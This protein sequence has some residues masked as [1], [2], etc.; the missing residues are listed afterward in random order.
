MTQRY[1]M[2]SIT[3]N[4]EAQQQSI[5][6]TTANK[7]SAHSSNSSASSSN[8]SASS[9]NSSASSSNSS[10][11]SSMNNNS[12]SSNSMSSS[13]S[14]NNKD[15]SAPLRSKVFRAT[16]GVLI[17]KE[18]EDQLMLCIIPVDLVDDSTPTTNINKKRKLHECDDDVADDDRLPTLTEIDCDRFFMRVLN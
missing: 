14:G 12:S 2:S 4:Q 11:S 7:E 13:N 9:S 5:R 18:E 15:P 3:Q 16:G 6:F 8:S 10:S 1:A 17:P